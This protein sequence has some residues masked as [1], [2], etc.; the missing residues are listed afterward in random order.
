DSIAARATSGGEE[1]ARRE[2]APAADRDVVAAAEFQGLSGR[3]VADGDVASGRNVVGALPRRGVRRRLVGGEGGDGAVGGVDLGP[4]R[5]VE[6]G[7]VAG[8]PV[9]GAADRGVV[10]KAATGGDVDLHHAGGALLARDAQ[11]GVAS[12]GDDVIVA[13]VADQAE[14]AD[15]FG[16]GDRA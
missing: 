1:A 2:E 3:V 11:I 7:P 10:V 13:L 5:A 6:D 14:L 12:D 16:I 9:A 4:V 8:A 15:L